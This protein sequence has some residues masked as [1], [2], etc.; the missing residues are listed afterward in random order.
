MLGLFL[1]LGDL[2][3]AFGLWENKKFGIRIFQTIA[4]SQIIAYTIFKSYFGNQTP[5]VV[6]HFTTI[7][8]YFITS[9]IPVPEE[10]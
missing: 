7:L 9:Q 10:Q 4:F 1:L 8:F 6:V 3:A 2:V 5:L